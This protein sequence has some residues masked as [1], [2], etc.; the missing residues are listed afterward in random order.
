[1]SYDFK[2]PHSDRIAADPPPIPGE[3]T[4]P[5]IET[6]Q[7]RYV[8]PESDMESNELRAAGET[9]VHCHQTIAGNQAV[10]RHLNGTFQHEMCPRTA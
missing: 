5:N 7:E 10:I 1:M 3:T 9:C 8:D 2:P 6:A 4:G